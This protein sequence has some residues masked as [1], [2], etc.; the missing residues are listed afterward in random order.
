MHPS[1]FVA[2]VRDAAFANVFN[3]YVDRCEV[4]DRPDA[5]QR[6][7]NA[8]LALLIAAA[9]AEVDSLW[10]GRDLGYRG[11]RRT[12]LALT[13]DVHVAAHAARWGVEI[14][15]ATVGPA[16]AERTAS[17]IWNVIAQVSKPIFLW[18][19]FPFHPFERD[20]PFT[21]RSHNS[22]ERNAG[23][24][25][26]NELIKILRPRRIVALGRDAASTAERLAGRR[27]LF[28]VRHPSYGGQRDF[29]KQVAQIYDLDEATPNRL[30]LPQIH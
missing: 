20:D 27:E 1:K 9:R 23:E 12:G 25:L 15:R 21:N 26:L 8:L 10:V 4:Y 3:P 7:A 18:N 11:G 2:C 6:R 14:E 28:P 30:P 13:D 24:E 29:K 17:V 5:P 19:V 22:A 16:M